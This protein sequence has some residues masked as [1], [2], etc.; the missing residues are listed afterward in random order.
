M[1]TVILEAR[2]VLDRLVER[3]SIDV[4]QFYD[5]S[6]ALIDSAEYRRK[7]GVRTVEG[8]VV[9]PS[10]KLGQHFV[11]RYAEDGSYAGGRSEHA[12]G[13]VTEE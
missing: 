9:D 5:G 7:H 12:D 1:N 3:L 4:G 6:I 11:N 2:D 8:W 13:T 10:G